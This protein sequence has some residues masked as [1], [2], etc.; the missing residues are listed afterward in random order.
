[1]RKDIFRKSALDKISSLDQLDL[2][3]TVVNPAE[4]IAAVAV[5]V[6]LAIIIIWGFFGSI[7]ERVN[8]TGIFMDMDTINSV[9]SP[10]QGLLKDVF[11]E[12]GDYV[13]KGQVIAR[14]E[15]QDLLDQININNHKLD[16]LLRVRDKLET[17]TKNGSD[18]Q[19]T[20]RSLFEQGLI[21]E[22]EY[23]SSRQPEANITQ[24]INDMKQQ[25]LVQNEN[26][27]TSTQIIANANGYVQEIPVRHGDF[28]QPGTQI[29]VLGQNEDTNVM[30]AIVY[31]PAKQAKKIQSGMKIGICPSTIKQQE[32]G[33]IEGI[34]TNISSF[35]V[36]DQYLQA[37]LQNSSLVENFRKIENP[38]EI[39]VSLIPNPD[40]YSGYKWSSSK[41]PYEKLTAGVI[42][43]GTVTVESK[44][45]IELVIPT[46]KEKLL[47][48]GDDEEQ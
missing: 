43:T 16:E 7:P 11:V 41:G 42:C 14:V 10:T 30:H 38:V 8:G 27:Q 6:I 47:G 13:K 37:S 21:T 12:R 39:E 17:G 31:F 32:Y 23:I 3:M 44:R 26:Y 18:K 28:I 20:L 24:Q 45:P 15:R 46:I 25:I 4:K 34:V 36:S 2:A 48:I 33:Y 1:M 35:P 19:Q 40:T 5:A 29:I 9:K 22:N